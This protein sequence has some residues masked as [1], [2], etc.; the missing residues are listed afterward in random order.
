VAHNHRLPALAAD[1][2]QR[3]VAVIAATSTPAVV[4]AKAATSTI[5]IVFETGA[6][7]IR[8][9][10]VESLNRPGGNATGVTQM[11]LEVAPK[12]LELLHELMPAA[13]VM[14]YLVNPSNTAV[15][16]STTNQMQAAARTLGLELHVLDAASE[17]D[18]DAVFAKIDALHASGLVITGDA[19]LSSRLGQ[20]ATL[21]ARHT[22]PAVSG[23]REFVTA[24]GLVSYGA[25]LADAYRLTGGYVGRILKGDKPADLPVQQATKIELRFNLKTAKALGITV[26]LTLLGRADDVIE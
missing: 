20:L 18:F 23:N 12:R 2:V 17:S 13:R 21:A 5:P 10:I 3:K 7:P 8:L 4:A 25:D 26:P 22:L 1:L 14:A 15:A 11:N 9:G 16:E 6:D 19:F 24:G